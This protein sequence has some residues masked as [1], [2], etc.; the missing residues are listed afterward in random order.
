MNTRVTRP[1][2]VYPVGTV[3]AERIFPNCPRYIRRLHGDEPSADVP[4]LGHVPSN[5]EMETL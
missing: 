1:L 4:G 3:R 5:R 2:R